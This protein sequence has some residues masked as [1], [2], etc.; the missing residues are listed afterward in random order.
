LLREGESRNRICGT[1]LPK[2]RNPGGERKRGDP[3]PTCLKKHQAP[4]EK[5]S[6]LKGERKGKVLLYRKECPM[7]LLVP[8]KRRRGMKKGERAFYSRGARA[9]Y[10]RQR[11]GGKGGGMTILLEL[12]RKEGNR[13]IS[14]GGERKGTGGDSC[15]RKEKKELSSPGE[16][17]RNAYY[18]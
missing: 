18:F 8:G 6:L 3:Q 11:E 15:K 7:Q 5:P 12:E 13:A 4:K 2:R 10:Q 9:L 14:I 17:K 16:E 1:D